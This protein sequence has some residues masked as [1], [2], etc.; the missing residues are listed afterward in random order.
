MQNTKV[1]VLCVMVLWHSRCSRSDFIEFLLAR[2]NSSK[3]GSVLAS[4]VILTFKINLKYIRKMLVLHIYILYLCRVNED[5]I[6]APTGEILLAHG[7]RRN[8]VN[9]DRWTYKNKEE[10]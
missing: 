1:M 10:K 5:K 9:G 6:C 8:R 2:H 4:I 3:L 7:R